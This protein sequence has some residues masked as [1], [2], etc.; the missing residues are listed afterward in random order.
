[1]KTKTNFIATTL[2]SIVY[3]LLPIISLA[4]D[5]S[6]DL[7]FNNNGIA[8]TPIGSSNALAGPS[9]LSVQSDGKIIVGG[10]SFQNGYTG[11]TI[12]RYL[13]NGSLDSTFGNNGVVFTQIGMSSGITSIALQ[14]DGKIIVAGNTKL[15]SSTF[16]FTAIRY[17][18]NGI[19]DATFGNGGVAMIDVENSSNCY[20]IALKQNGKIVL[21]GYSNFNFNTGISL[22]QLNADGTLDTNFGTGGVSIHHFAESPDIEAWAMA[23][24]A[25]EK[26]V[27]TGIIYDTILQRNK[28]SIARFNTNGSMDMGFGINGITKTSLNNNTDD[29]GNAVAIQ[30][31]GKILIAAN[32]LCDAVILRYNSNGL[33]DSSFGAA[34][35]IVTNFE[36]SECASPYGIIIQSDGKIIAAG[37]SGI[38]ALNG[39]GNFGLI[40]FNSNGTIDNTFGINGKVATD[41]SNGNNDVAFS[42]K[43]HSDGKLIVSGI[44]MN[45][46]YYNF[47]VSRYNNTITS[48]IHTTDNQTSEIIIYPNPFLSSAILQT[49]KFFNDAALIFYNSFGQQVKQIKNI[50]GQ[51]IILYRDNLQS[52]LYFIHLV[53]DNK[54]ILTKKLIITD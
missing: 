4:Q 40:R 29:A 21:S 25:N 53:Q 45:N 43:Q 1:M 52:G 42:V 3:F 8:T 51:T 39:N 44:S 19:P 35:I 54:E 5:G 34:G 9:A 14:N 28:I 33:P 26:I 6:L 17:D 47:A 38:N 7:T 48:G 32:S 13:T 30:S 22:V 31:D 10:G 15:N 24:D 49:N 36:T 46:N 11:F 16:N 50:S 12:V 18:T 37:V 20:N 2:F 41:L 27:T 23:L